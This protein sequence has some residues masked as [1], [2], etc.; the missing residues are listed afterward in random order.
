MTSYPNKPRELKKFILW[1]VKSSIVKC[2]QRINYVKSYYIRDHNLQQTQ[3]KILILKFDDHQKQKVE[4]YIH[5]NHP[6]QTPEMVYL[7]P[8]DVNEAY[9]KRIES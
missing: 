6:Y 5:K 2:V 1:L 9:L 8:H 3:E 7:H 4:S